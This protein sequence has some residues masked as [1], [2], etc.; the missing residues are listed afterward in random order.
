MTDGLSTARECWCCG[1]CMYRGG[2]RPSLYVVVAAA[3]NATARPQRTPDAS[4][5]APPASVFTPTGAPVSQPVSAASSNSTSGA[6]GAA[7]ATAAAAALS[8]IGASATFSAGQSGG[9][10]LVRVNNGMLTRV[11]EHACVRVV[12]SVCVMLCSVC[13]SCALFGAQ[14]LLQERWIQLKY[15]SRAVRALPITAVSRRVCVSVAERGYTYTIRGPFL[16]AGV[17]E[18]RMMLEGVPWA[19]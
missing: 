19:L 17:V 16:T 1:A 14:S 12:F 3:T 5:G 13:C 2:T 4:S 7:G 15:Q 9:P 18:R 11:R 6:A 10:R 8:S